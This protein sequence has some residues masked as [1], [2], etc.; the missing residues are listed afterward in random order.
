MMSVRNIRI[1]ILC[2]ASAAIFA[3][4]PVTVS[5][6]PPDAK[7]VTLQLAVDGDGGCSITVIPEIGVIQHGHNAKIKKVYWVALPN[8]QH[9][10]LFWELR[11]DPDKGGASENYFGNVDLACGVDNIKVQPDKPTIDNAEWPYAV[12]VFSCVDGAKTEQLCTVDPRIRWES[13]PQ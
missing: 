10:Q 6:D 8:D 3:V 4:G 2:A 1:P 13:L 5:A 11:W 9:P 7:E 12:S